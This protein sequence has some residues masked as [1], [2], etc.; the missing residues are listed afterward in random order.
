MG[1]AGGQQQAYEWAYPEQ[2]AGN[3]P[4]GQPTATAIDAG[5]DGTPLTTGPLT[6]GA[7]TPRKTQK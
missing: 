1:G 6:R 4:T 7:G 5:S 3:I 2:A